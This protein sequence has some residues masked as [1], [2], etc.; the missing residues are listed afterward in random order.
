VP[1]PKKSS[2]SSRSGGGGRSGSGTSGSRRA[3]GSGTP[4]GGTSGRARSAGATGKRNSGRG[5]ATASRGGATASRGPATPSRGRGPRS[6]SRSSGSGP[7][8]G[9][10][11]PSRSRSVGASSAAESAGSLRELLMGNVVN[12]LNLVMLTSERLQ[13]AFDDAVERGRVT[14]DD[15][16]ELLGDLM[17]RGR[18]QTEDVLTDIEE[19]LAKQVDQLETATADVRERASDARKLATE[20]PRLTRGS[21]RKAVVP[22][23]VLREVDR[24]RRV[25]GLGP[26]FPIMGYDELAAGEVIDRLGDLSAAQLR[27]VRDHERRNANRKTVLNAV[28]RKL[29]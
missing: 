1:Q 28:E 7:R 24:A 10:A 26:S 13:E 9:A 29:D 8:S 21:V 2:G 3:S 15:A 17:R 22:D 19:L 20:A 25:T 27:K 12:P 6:S 4:S 16:E 5:G 11:P 23:R 18:K 14:R